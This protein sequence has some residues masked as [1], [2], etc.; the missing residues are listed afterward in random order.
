MNDTIDITNKKTFEVTVDGEKFCVEVAIPHDFIPSSK[1]NLIRNHEVK[2]IPPVVH[3]PV[4]EPVFAKGEHG[5]LAPMPGNI[6]SYE[7]KIGDKVKM[8]D[9]VVV[10]EA[11]KMYNNLYASVDGVIESIPYNSGDNVKKYDV[12]CVIKN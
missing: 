3:M 5:I 9:V 2:N 8:G 10:L 11:M 12:L 4:K 1:S 6:I 7:K